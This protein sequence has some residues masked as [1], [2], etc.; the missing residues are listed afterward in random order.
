MMIVFEFIN[1]IRDTTKNINRSENHHHKT[2]DNNRKFNHDA[3]PLGKSGYD[4]TGKK[5]NY[6]R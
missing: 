2:A 1:K 4:K 5:S 3:A 6:H